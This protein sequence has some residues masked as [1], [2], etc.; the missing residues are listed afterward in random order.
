[1]K[2][3]FKVL[4]NVI[5]IVS[6]I[7]LVVG[8]SPATPEAET[9]KI[10]VWING[11]DSLIGPSEQKLPQ[12]QWYISQ[13]IDR[14]EKANPNTEVELVVQSDALQAHQTFRTAGLA[15][16]APDIAN[17]WAGQFIFQLRDVT[18]DITKYI[19]EEDIKNISG[20]DTVTLDFKEGNPIIG[21]P[22]PDNQMTFFLYNK[23]IIEEVGLDYENN[24]PRSMDVFFSDLQKIKDAGYTPIAADE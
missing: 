1:M 14:F 22:M 19:P 21:Y 18:A 6:T 15:G 2:T 5:I 8:C 12:D 4:I 10:T 3:K 13:A 24:P 7:L 23:K 16:N 9:A 20:W 11:R 17:L